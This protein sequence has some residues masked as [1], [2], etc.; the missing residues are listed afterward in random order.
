MTEAFVKHFS[1]SAALQIETHR[2]RFHASVPLLDRHRGK[3]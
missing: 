2:I 3:H 1:K